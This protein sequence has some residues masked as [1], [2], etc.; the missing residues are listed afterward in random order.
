MISQHVVAKAKSMDDLKNVI[1]EDEFGNKVNPI[2]QVVFDTHHLD[3][4][5]FSKSLSVGASLISKLAMAVITYG[6]FANSPFLEV[7]SRR[8]TVVSEGANETIT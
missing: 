8:Y 3:K 1:F 2:I 5:T 7:L 4:P 6:T